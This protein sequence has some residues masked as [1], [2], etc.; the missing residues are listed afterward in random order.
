[1]NKIKDIAKSISLLLM[2]LIT[3]AAWGQDDI[4][5]VYYIAN[6]ADYDSANPNGN[7]YLVPAKDPQQAHYADA[8]F[9]NE[10]C[11]KSGSGDYTGDN[12]GDPEQPFLTTFKTKQDN[13]SVWVISKTGDYYYL[14]HAITGKYVVYEP[15]YKDAK[16]R[17]SMHLL[18]AANLGD[19]AKFEITGSG[20]YNFRPQNVKNENTVNR[21]FNPAGGN[22]NKYYGTTSTY[23]HLGMVGLYNVNTGSSLWKLEPALLPAPTITYDAEANTFTISYDLLPKGY[24]IRYTKDGS[25]PTV[26]GGSSTHTYDGNPVE[27]T[28]GYTVNAVVVRYGLVLTEM[29]STR[30]GKPEGPTITPSADCSNKITITA[31]AG[32]EVYYTLDGTEPDKNSHPYLYPFVQN[33]N[34][35]IKA[36]SYNGSVKSDVSTLNYVSQYTAKPTIK[37]NGMT[38]TMTSNGSIYY[39]TDGSTPTTNSTPYTGPITLENGTGEVTYRAIAK[40]TDK[41][42]SCEEELTVGL[43]YFINSIDD[44]NDIDSHLDERCILTADIDASS[45]S[46]SISGFTGIFDGDYHVISGLTKPLFTGINNGTVKNVF[47]RQVHINQSGPVGAIT[48]VANGYTRIYNCGILPNDNTFSTRRRQ[49]SLSSSDSYC[50]GL[51]GWLKDNSRVVNCFSYANIN[52]GTDVAGIVGHND[53]ASTAK[54]ENGFYTELKTAVVNCMFYGNITSGTNRWPVYGGEKMLNTGATGINNYDYYRVEANLGLTDNNHFNCS[55]P[56]K[57]EYLTKYEY[58]RYL[59]NSNRELCGWWVK[60]DVAPSTLSIAAVQAIDKDASLMGKWVL[61]PS[62]APYPILKP[63]GYYASAIN[64]DPVKRIDPDTKQW[65]DRQLL[66]RNDLIAKESPKTDGQTYGKLRVYIKGGD[67]HGGSTYKDIPITAMDTINN[68]FCYGKIQLP[69]Y[70]EVFGDPNGDTWSEKYADNYTNMVVTGWDITGI[71]GGNPGTFTEDWQY[72]YN[73]ADRKCTNKDKERLFAQGG[74]YYVPDGVESITITAHWATAT[75]ID[76][77]DHSYDR[78]YFSN[79]APSQSGAKTGVHFAPAGYRTAPGGLT[80]NNGTISNNI[81]SNGTVYD[82][83]LV[84]VGN[85]QY[86]TSNN[87]IKGA[88]N[89]DGVTIMSA[90]L[91]L[92]NEPDYCLEWQL[93]QKT[94]RYNICPIRFDF[95]P[96]VELGLAM[97]EDGSKQLFSMG[98]YRPLGHFEVTETTLIHFGQFEFGNISRSLDAPLILNGGIYDQYTK[99]TKS[100]NT[101]D[102]HIDYVIVG[103]HVYIPAFTPGAHVNTNAKYPTRHCAV[104]VIGGKIDNLYLTGNFNEDVTPNKDDPHCYIDGGSFKQI[105]AAGKEG[106]RGDVT[107]V[108]N[109]SIIDEFYGGSTLSNQLVTGDINVTI[110]NSMVT[111]YC[112]GPKFGDMNLDED[113][114]ANNKKVI[115]NATG[116]TFGVYYGGG[117][118]GT[119]YVQYD[120]RDNTTKASNYNWN[121]TGTNQGAVNSYTPGTY[122]DRTTGYMANY[123]MEIVNTSA[124]TSPDTA[125]FR[126]YFYA[127]QFSATNTGPITNNL[128]NCRVLTNFYGG[129]NLGGVIGDVTSTLK[130]TEVLGSAFGA[131]YSAKIPQVTIY[132]RTKAVPTVNIYTGMITNP[133]GNEDGNTYTWTNDA[134]LS[135]SNPISGNYIFTEES[136]DNL[137]T[138]TG[139]VTL[140]IE[141]TS[142]IKGSAYGGGESSNATGNTEVNVL[143]GTVGEVYG[144]GALANVSGNTQVNLKG[145]TV[146]GDVY[147]GGKGRLATDEVTAIAAT[148]GNATV[149]LN[150]ELADD[151]TGC[152]VKGN[153]FG[154]NN[155]NGTPTGAVTVHI[156]RT[157]GYA[158]HWRTGYQAQTAAERL[159][160]LENIDDAQHS[161]E[162]AAVYGGGNLAAYVPTDL[163]NGKTHVI[164]DGCS[165]TSVRQVYGGGNAASTPATWV[166]INGT[167]EIEEVFGGGNGKDDIS[168]DGVNYIA[169]PGAN[170]GFHAYTDNQDDTDTPEERAANYG[171][172]SGA[173]NVNINGGRIHRVYGGSNTKG[174]VRQIAV[175]MLEELSDC[176]F[177]VDE[178]YG[179]GKSAS[180]DGQ[181]KLEMAC[182]PGLKN[183]YGGAE[184]ANI[185]NDVTLNITNGDFN[186]VFGGNNVSGTING[187]ITVNIEE[188]GCHHITIGQLYGGGNQ[189][190]YIGPLKTGST[191]ERQGPTLN[192]RSF[193]SIGEVYG[194]GY[195]KTATVT[196]DTYV[197]INV[198][199]GKNF[200]ANQ[201]TE[202]ARTN[203]FTGN[204]TIS[205]AEFRRT[206]DGGFELDNQGNRIIDH[207]T[208]DLYLPPFTSGIGAINNVYGGGNAAEVIG[209]THVNIGTT[210][211]ESVIFTTPTSEALDANRTH[212]VKGANIVGNIYGG[213]NA[214]QVTGKTKVQI[215]KKVDTTSP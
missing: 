115:T 150:K 176:S 212:T 15:P 22:Q 68:D 41:A 197:N 152:V 80:V 161:Y 151:A 195:G 173:A 65:V 205:F 37:K 209:N 98:C 5:G 168:L 70:N 114:P 35:T 90:D 184:N 153:I 116:T 78:V 55:F 29:A 135:T 76:N 111:K 186:R 134:S 9:H 72:G 160:A 14:I 189:A 210:I 198:C 27:V 23:L 56:V 97:K 196:G 42:A 164:I 179:G 101:A 44:L 145:G 88:K 18:T 138:V 181:S 158:G 200:G 95:L 82:H 75:Y 83:A 61:D 144:G 112:G 34:T 21:F 52:G 215:G 6:N 169:N 177:V 180:M 132:N 119:S 71:S 64:Q 62:I 43:G 19:N 148:V 211:G 182:I 54:E 117:N 147:G 84:L 32:S 100:K 46:A 194:G 2:L 39:T 190:P 57:E 109:H 74:Y 204:K 214:A 133:D 191:T 154:C 178:A 130:D 201:T 202:L 92:D 24:S 73:F 124:G 104:N 183:A 139:K 13:N 103:G 8:Y 175:T 149:E 125:V 136:L 59:L 87:D 110:D 107:F 28:G 118:G 193:S 143:G 207:K 45:L 26:E 30:V 60:S 7:W 51:V 33:E 40:S 206:A 165:L 171:Y 10:F 122:R 137:G 166:E 20:D 199:D 1:M 85:H 146:T 208:I 140:R 174:N 96:I 31:E 53:F 185:N 121:A 188:T 16:N 77:T 86:R 213:G 131:G 102:D 108:I 81:P 4:S 89:T 91:D 11:N 17:K 50:G 49:P 142:D 172:G 127:A 155:L 162:V 113:N 94:D 3:S 58:Y 120:K 63:A 25:T 106:I 99:G 187:T 141:G 69:Y 105:A 159:A 128:N 36:V 38:I 93:G 123:E 157:Q 67:N 167:Y 203:T 79:G 129:G 126:T 192:V 48:D 12:Y 170:V 47:L 163:A 66:T 156:Y